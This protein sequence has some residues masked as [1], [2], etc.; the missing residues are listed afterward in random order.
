MQEKTK[1]AFPVAEV[2]LMEDRAHVVRRGWVTVPAGGVRLE[3]DNITPVLSDKTLS[4]V[5]PEQSGA[6]LVD[7]QV[8]RQEICLDADQPE[9]IAALDEKLR[10]LQA[11]R[12]EIAAEEQLL[13]S[14]VEGL[15]KAGKL[16]IEELVEDGAWGQASPEPWR[17]QLSKLHDTET[18][19]LDQQAE[20]RVRLTELREDCADL[21]KRRQAADRP[22]S[23]R[24]ASLVI[25]LDASAATELELR[26]DYVVPGA[27]WRPYHVASLRGHDPQILHFRCEACIWQNTGEDWHDVQL[28]FSSLRPTLGTDPPLLETDRLSARKTDKTVVVETREQT[29]H[30]TGLGGG[31][32]QIA[33]EVPGIDDGGKTMHLRAQASANVPSDGRPHRVPLFEFESPASC[34]LVCMPEL[35]PAVILRSEQENRGALPILAGPVDLIR[36]SGLVGRTH[37]LYIGS[38]E[39][40]E[41]GWG[42]NLAMRV[43]RTVE[44]LKEETKLLSSWSTRRRRVRVSLSNIGPDHETVL[45]TERVPVSEVEKVEILPEA[46]ETT[47]QARP[48]KDGF[49]HWQVAL[50]AFASDEVLLAYA[51]KRHPDVVGLSSI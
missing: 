3:V 8:V 27:C 1:T 6:R 41:L 17:Q 51:V 50:P 9:E 31:G 14:Q 18:P 25:D 4:V 44:D 29:V 45:V 30:T 38:G 37:V 23:V 15:R 42:P 2:T 13:A 21:Q 19:L 7:V 20:I 32:Q 48:D 49:V 43:H 46:N 36:Q 16:A 10:A 34:G 5:V 11:E 22:Q 35:A 24:R 12:D 26:V 40:F 33:P 39:K 47:D 28:F